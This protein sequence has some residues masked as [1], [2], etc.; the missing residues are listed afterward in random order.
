MKDAAC[1]CRIKKI[2]Y[3]A[4]FITRSI[5]VF[6]VTTNRKKKDKKRTRKHLRVYSRSLIFIKDRYNYSAR[7]I[8]S[9]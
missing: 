4:K 7:K 8:I 2:I 3:V 6:V 9:P 1:V 5:R